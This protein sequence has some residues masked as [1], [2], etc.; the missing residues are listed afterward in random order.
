[1]KIVI[2]DIASSWLKELSSALGSG[3][4][5]NDLLMLAIAIVLL[6]VFFASIVILKALKSVLHLTHPHFDAEQKMQRAFAKKEKSQKR[7]AYW[8]KL[9]GLRPISEEKEIEIDHEYDG[10]KELDNPVPLWFNGLFYASIAFSVVYLLSYHVFGW[11]M[12]QEQEYEHE[13]AKAERARQ[14]WLVQAANNVD[15]S[16]VMLDQSATVIQAG[17]VLFAQNCAVCHGNAGEGGIGP[18]LVDEYWIHGHDIQ[19]VFRVVKYGVPEKGMV[20]W[21][22]SLTPAQIAEVSNYIISLKGTNPPNQKEPQG[23]KVEET[24]AQA[25]SL[26]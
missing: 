16:N 23:A 21:E 2:L 3:N 10:I 15:E 12:L 18:N 17:S 4:L 19:G 7:R 11:G 14:D 6:A 1:M 20:P 25:A 9:M 26:N 13:M 8:N 24:P 22:Q 5:Y